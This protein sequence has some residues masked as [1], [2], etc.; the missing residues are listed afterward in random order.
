MVICQFGKRRPRKWSQ[1]KKKKS[2]IDSVTTTDAPGR[3]R[4]M[5]LNYFVI[6]MVDDVD[7][8]M[9]DVKDLRKLVEFVSITVTKR[10]PAQ[11]TD[12]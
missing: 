1:V 12:A 10:R 5:V 7:V 11:S 4:N 2:S 6:P 3:Q 9:M 8:V